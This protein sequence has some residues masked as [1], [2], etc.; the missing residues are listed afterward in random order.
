MRRLIDADALGNKM[1]H[2]AF[3]NDASYN[4]SNPMAKW[5]SGLWIRYKMFENAINDVPTL[6]TKEVK[7]FDEDENVWKIGE[8]IVG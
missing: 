8:I 3:E 2:E 6:N 4:E 5:D 1:Y 7:Y